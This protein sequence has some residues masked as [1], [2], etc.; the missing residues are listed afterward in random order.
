MKFIVSIIEYISEFLKSVADFVVNYFK[1]VLKFF[2]AIPETIQ[3]MNSCVAWLPTYVIPFAM[4][5]IAV[6]VLFLIIRR[7]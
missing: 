6:S 3:I 5:F 7:N 1:N 4:W 2:A